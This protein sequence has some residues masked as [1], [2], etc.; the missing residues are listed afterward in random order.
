[1]SDA[2]A[3]RKGLCRR[4]ISGTDGPAQTVLRL[5]GWECLERNPGHVPDRREALS[6][7]RQPEAWKSVSV[8]SLNRAYMVLVETVR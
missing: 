1:M 2:I 5:T 8:K 7:S 6:P 3:C 4:Q